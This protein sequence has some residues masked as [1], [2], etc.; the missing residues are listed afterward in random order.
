MATQS[1]WF[2]W[3]LSSAVF[4]ALTA[5][6]A[7]VGLQGVDSDFATLIRTAFIL[8]V[9]MMFVS[10][11]DKWQS[12]STLSPATWGWLLASALATGAS[13]ICYFRALQAGNTSPVAAVDKL[14]LVLVAV[15]AFAFLHERLNLREWLGIA[16]VSAGIITLAF[17]R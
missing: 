8:L 12:P 4:A 7:K 5:I 2:F 1:H 10:V 3:A 14:S 16:L 15:F 13:W 17:K 6:F 11:T 9:L